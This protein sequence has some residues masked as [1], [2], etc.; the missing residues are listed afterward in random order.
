VTAPGGFACWAF[1]ATNASRGGSPGDVTLPGL[2]ASG[3]PV[4]VWV[5]CANIVTI[6]VADAE[7]E[8]RGWRRIWRVDIATIDG[9]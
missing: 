2:A 9:R 4:P 6:E 5:R 8:T 3:L 1:T 7:R